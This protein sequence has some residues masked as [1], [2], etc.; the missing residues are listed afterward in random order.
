MKQNSTRIKY[1]T[2]YISSP[3]ERLRKLMSLLL[4][5]FPNILYTIPVQKQ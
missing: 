2:E 1:L 3:E 5:I 4:I